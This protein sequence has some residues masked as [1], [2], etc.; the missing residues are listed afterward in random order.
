MEKMQQDIQKVIGDAVEQTIDSSLTDLT[1]FSERLAIW[2]IR[3][4]MNDGSG[5]LRERG[6]T[7]A[8][9]IY[10]W[11]EALYPDYPLNPSKED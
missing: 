8:G 5:R 7:L 9:A 6:L 4:T 1:A 11:A 10:D 2:A 3:N